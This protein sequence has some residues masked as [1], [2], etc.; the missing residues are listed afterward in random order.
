MDRYQKLILANLEMDLALKKKALEYKI[1]K[2]A[3]AYPMRVAVLKA[4][5]NHKPFGVT[6]EQVIESIMVCEC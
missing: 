3:G 2:E 4:K 6:L 1:K 5:Q